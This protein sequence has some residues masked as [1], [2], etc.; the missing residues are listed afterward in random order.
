MRGEEA[1]PFESYLGGIAAQARERLRTLASTGF[2]PRLW[3]RDPTLWKPDASHRE[4]SAHR[5]GWLGSTGIMQGEARD[6]AAFAREAADDGITTAFLLGIGGAALVAEGLASIFGASESGLE[7]VVLDTTDP[8][9]ILEAE[10]L[11]DLHRAIF[12]LSSKSGTAVE[13]LALQAH[14]TKRLDDLGV[15]GP[16]GRF[17][18]VTDP[19]SPLEETARA[20][21]FRR[22]FL[23]PPDIGERY[24]ALSFTGMVPAALLGV[25]LPRLLDRAARLSS[26]CGPSRDLAANPGV[27][28]GAILAEAALAGRDKI[29]L[30]PSPE[31]API[32]PWIEHLIAES[33]GKDGRGLLPIEGEALASP[34]AYGSD[35]LFVYLRLRGGANGTTDAGVS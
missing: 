21:G 9:S 29:T 12:L 19:G 7:C 20:R 34:D 8:S 4:A 14:F 23:T 6:L 5:L 16:G 2:V 32:A 24:A 1:P 15:P 22:V 28:L 17:V 27:H 31:I 33:T 26:A 35:R 3:K 18:A 30:V 13:T 11:H 25:N 10:R